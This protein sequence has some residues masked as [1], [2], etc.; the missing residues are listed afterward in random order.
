[1]MAPPFYGNIE[2]TAGRTSGAQVRVLLVNEDP[3]SLGR[4]RAIL[5]RLGCQ[6]RA[7]SSF[8]VGVHCFGGKP[9]DLILLDQGSRGF[10]GREVLAHAMEVDVELRVIVLARAYDRKCYWEAMQSGALAYVVEPVS[11]AEIVALVETFA[12]TRGLAYGKSGDRVTPASA[13]RE[14]N[15]IATARH[16]YRRQEDY[17]A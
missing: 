7:S 10:E 9:F 13:S 6:V 12:P 14:C 17:A 4:H 2:K 1:M 16:C 11:R 15:S 8:A 3:G 5:Q